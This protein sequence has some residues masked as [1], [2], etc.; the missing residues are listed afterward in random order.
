MNDA[1]YA[2]KVRKAK[3]DDPIIN[4]KTDLKHAKCLKCTQTCKQSSK[5][6]ILACDFTGK[7]KG[8]TK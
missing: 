5:V 2:A 1:D 4:L 3:K 8:E 7:D 6:H